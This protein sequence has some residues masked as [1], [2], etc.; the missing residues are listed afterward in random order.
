MTANLFGGAVE[1]AYNPSSL[2]MKSIEHILILVF[3]YIAI[4][5]TEQVIRSIGAS[6]SR[7]ASIHIN[8]NHVPAGMAFYIR[9][10]KGVGILSALHKPGNLAQH[11]VIG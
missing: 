7:N 9:T 4:N 11:I 6:T 1:A 5:V 2:V 10:G 8:C 3:I